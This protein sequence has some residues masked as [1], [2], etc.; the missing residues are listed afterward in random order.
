MPIA[1]PWKHLQD[2]LIKIQNRVVRDDFNDIGDDNWQENLNTPRDSLR[3]ACILKKTD[4]SILTL[5][6]LWLFYICLRKAQDLQAPIFGVPIESYQEE[7]KYKPQIKL[8]F[9]Q[10]KNAVPDSFM[11]IQSEITFR[12]INESSTSISEAEARSL[13]LEIKNIFSTAGSGFVW[14]KGKFKVTY[15]DPD[16][17]Y[18][19]RINASSKAEGEQLIKKFLQ[20]KNHAF[21]EDKLNV[22]TPNRDSLNNPTAF[23]TIMGKQHR[24]HRW[25]PVANVR[26]RWASLHIH[27]Q[28]RP[29]ILCD[30]TGTFIDALV[31]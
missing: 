15:F 4:S 19:F 13:G 22:V 1:S 27:A 14:T 26:F 11:P 9:C 12:L 30:I 20:I 5:L 31:K 10:D 2:V 18:D 3:S 23:V 17:G 8:Y 6:R 16:H 7:V 25:R 24:A 21:V 29:I 28:R